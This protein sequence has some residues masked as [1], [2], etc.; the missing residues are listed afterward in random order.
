[1]AGKKKSPES[2][3]TL[4]EVLYVVETEES[5]TLHW[6]TSGTG[7]R[8]AGREVGCVE[9]SKGYKGF[10]Y[11]GRTYKTHRVLWA[12]EYGRW[13]EHWL[14]HRNGNRTDNR[15][16]NLRE[17]TP[18]QNSQNR[19]LNSDNTSGVRGVHWDKAANKWKAQIKVNS[20]SV[21]LG[22]H[23]DAELAGL[24]YAVAAE[25]FHGEFCHGA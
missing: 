10:R 12:L 7:K 18:L 23:D 16:S 20:K 1:M 21:N 15:S 3:E 19:K 25:R 11:N 6:R 8:Y 4:R 2:I 13:P 17:A 5:R 24:I 9:K 22:R 14:D